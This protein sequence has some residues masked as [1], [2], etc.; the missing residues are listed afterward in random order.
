[1][2]D[3]YVDLEFLDLNGLSGTLNIR[4]VNQVFHQSR[5]GFID[6]VM[7]SFPSEYMCTTAKLK[8]SSVSG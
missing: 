2:L 3:I 4:W 6:W 8:T 1:M 5:L 7:P